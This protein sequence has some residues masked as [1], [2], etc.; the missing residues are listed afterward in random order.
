MAVPNQS[1]SLGDGLGDDICIPFFDT[2][3]HFTEEGFT[4]LVNVIDV[5]VIEKLA[6]IAM[7]NYEEA[8]NI[9]ATKNLSIGIGVKEGFAEIT[10]RHLHRFEM[11][12]KMDDPAFNEVFNSNE[13]LSIVKQILGDDAIVVNRSV[14]ISLPGSSDQAWHCDGPHI[15][16][17][18]YLPCHCLNVFIPLVNIN[19]TNG[20]TEFRPSSQCLTRDFQKQYLAAFIGKRLKPIVAPCL[21]KG[22]VLLF[23]Y[24]V[25]HRGKSNSSD[26]PRPILVF[27]FAK[28]F[29]RD[30]LNFS[31]RSLF[32]A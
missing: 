22:D 12:Y 14:V 2:C 3:K 31:K 32:E 18:E 1:A 7:S 16:A 27:T 9:I 20:P 30:V 15:S 25:L 17:V 28:S 6:A 5:D 21:S 11:P 23:D 19:H 13:I 4:T 29:F 10:Q 8:M 26:S 24:R